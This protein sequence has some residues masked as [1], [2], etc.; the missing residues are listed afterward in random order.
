MGIRCFGAGET[1]EDA[2]HPAFCRSGNDKYL[3]I[4]FG[5]SVI[6][7][8]PATINQAGVAPLDGPMILREV[9]RHV[10]AYPDDR[11]VVVTHWNYEFEKYPQPGH[12]QLARQ[13]VD[14]GAY[15][16]IGHHPHIVGPIERYKGKTIAYSVG[17]WAFSYGHY[18]EKELR[19]PE[20]SFD[21]IAIE[22]GAEDV[23][24]HARFVPPS[25]VKYESSEKVH[26]E[27]LGLRAD[28]EGM[29]HQAYV[30]WFARHRTK[31][32]GL[33]IYKSA[34][35]SVS[36]TLKDNWVAFRQLLIDVAVRLR[37]KSTKRRSV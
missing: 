21:Q 32:R 17:N 1:I 2:V 19:F 6:G 14:L 16:V 20:P 25:T 5:W 30:T 31:R 15:A 4:G 29:S 28:F 34:S 35:P 13:I 23:V 3:L 37:I 7:C 33:P 12:R 36:N 26:T 11:V 9:E 8:S 24:H 22:L 18:F 27:A 10:C